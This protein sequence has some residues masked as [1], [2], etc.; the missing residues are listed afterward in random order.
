[1]YLIRGVDTSSIFPLPRLKSILSVAVQEASRDTSLLSRVHSL[2]IRSLPSLLALLLHS[3]H[4]ESSIFATT[5]N[6]S[7]V[8][9]DDLSTPFL[10]NYAGGFEEEGTRSKSG[11]K[12]YAD[13][14]AMK[15]TNILNELAY[16]LASL[17]V[18]HN[19]AVLT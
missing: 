19:I 17:A 4:T 7:L 13:S 11:K 1:M 15:R 3:A 14:S 5:P 2:S 16:K 18:K 9:I 12:D 8:V 6:L 10:A